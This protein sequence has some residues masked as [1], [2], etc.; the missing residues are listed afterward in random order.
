MPK[1]TR[2]KTTPDLV[3]NNQKEEIERKADQNMGEDA[4]KKVYVLKKRPR[5]YKI[6][7]E[8][9]LNPAQYDVVKSTEPVSMVIAGAGTGKT[10]TLVYRVSWLIENGTPPDQILLVTFTNKASREMLSRVERLLGQQPK[11]LWGGTFHHIANL[12]LRKYGAVLNLPNNFSILDEGDSVQVFGLCLAPFKEAMKETKK[13]KR[14]PTAKQLNDIYQAHI[15]CNQSVEDV[16]TEKYP[17]YLEEL[18]GIV[19]VIQAYETEKQSKNFLDFG[20]L[21]KYWLKLLQD[22]RAGP[23]ICSKFKYVLVD[24][25]QDV[26]KVQARIIES[27]AQQGANVMVVGD[28]AQSIYSFRGADIQNLLDFPK[29]FKNCKIFYLEQNYRST[30]EILD[31]TNECIKNNIHQFKKKLWTDRKAGMKATV[32][33]ADNIDDQSLFVVDKVLEYRDMGV[34]LNEMAV[35]FRATYHSNELQLALNEADIPYEVRGGRRFFEHRHIKDVISFLRILNNS[36]DELAWTRC[37][38]LVEGIGEKS[39][40]RIFE[41]ISTFADPL[42]EITNDAFLPHLRGTRVH[43]NAWKQFVGIIKA[44][45]EKNVTN[46]AIIIDVFL[47]VFY[48]QYLEKTFPNYQ[49][50]ILEINQLMVYAQSFPSMEEFISHCVIDMKLEGETIALGKTDSDEEKLILSTIHQAK[51]LEWKVVF[52]IMASQGSFPI[53]RVMGDTRQLEEERRLFY[54]ACTR[55]Q[56]HL[57][58]IHPIFSRFYYGN[59]ITQPSQFIRE[60]PSKFYEGIKIQHGN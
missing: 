57:Y 7:Y 4:E 33:T 44:I 60:I 5:K 58:V 13:L 49:E 59:E 27:I 18:K 26:N 34:A 56:D 37:L 54:V 12:L 35:L 3:I 2:R 8:K 42:H 29:I 41:V 46:P 39:A 10:R 28:D 53:S 51:G 19:Q 43:K 36:L 25:Y 40:V 20:D 52:I 24:E 16:L 11:G 32:A 31:F 21:L 9:E 38:Q 55:A 14:F 50:R 47:Q 1:K 15:D 6:D 30:P 23:T 48:Q 45:L 17:A 22:P